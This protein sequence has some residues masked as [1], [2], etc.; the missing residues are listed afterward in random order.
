MAAFESSTTR[1]EVCRNPSVQ[2]DMI[3]VECS[4]TGDLHATINVEVRDRYIAGRIAMYV[5][6]NYN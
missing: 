1:D 2:D 4:I 3:R 6:T 5:D